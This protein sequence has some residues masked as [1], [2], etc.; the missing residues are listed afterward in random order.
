MRKINVF[1]NQ[2]KIV[3][4][5]LIREFERALILFKWDNNSEVSKNN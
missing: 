2:I 4:S 3:L 5:G 1:D